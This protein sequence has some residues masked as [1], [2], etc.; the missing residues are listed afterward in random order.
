MH[1]TL[2][3]HSSEQF[4]P[5]YDQGV[6][7]HLEQSVSFRRIFFPML[8][9]RHNFKSTLTSQL[10]CLG[11]VSGDGKGSARSF[12]NEL[13]LRTLD[14]GWGRCRLNLH[15]P[16]IVLLSS[17]H[18]HNEVTFLIKTDGD[19]AQHHPV[20]YDI[21]ANPP[22]F[23]MLRPLVELLSGATERP[24]SSFIIGQISKISSAF[25]R[26]PAIGNQNR[27]HWTLVSKHLR[28]FIIR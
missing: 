3:M 17:S 12:T 4:Y 16:G 20:C 21:Q 22:F 24:G 19:N 27:Q 2:Q 5:S 10:R 9:L 11:D 7:L 15:W 23:R 13:R 28:S 25:S 8:I 26:T 14:I 18:F 1:R 6:I